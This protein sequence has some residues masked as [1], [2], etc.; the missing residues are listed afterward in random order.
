MTL[1]ALGIFSAAGAGGGFSSDYELISSTILGTAQASVSF[2]V[3]TF[4]STYKHLQIR[5]V[6]RDTTG[7]GAENFRLRF[8]GISTSS[9][10]R[11][12]LLGDGS[13]VSSFA[14]TSQTAA[15]GGT[16]PGSTAPANSFG[17]N[18]IDILDPFSSTKNTT[19]RTLVGL[20]P[21]SV[22]LYSGLFNNTATITSVELST[23][24]TF[25]SG[26]RFSLYGI[27]G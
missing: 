8:N 15:L 2:D 18:V 27:K 6:T 16:S 13:S 7:S 24:F 10:A 1:S 17:A 9:Y 5:A 20:T 14:E 22:R 23:V 4:A 11:H 19:T 3:S 21:N 26:S 25:T 12:A